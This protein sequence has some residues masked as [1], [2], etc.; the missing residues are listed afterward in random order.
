MEKEELLTV[1]ELARKMGAT[2]RALQYYD[3]EGLLKPSARSEGGRRLYTKKDMI[4]LH[5]ILSMKFLGF[6]LEEIKN[7]LIP[8]ETPQEVTEVLKKQADS[9]QKQIEGLTEALTAIRTLQEEIV[10]MQEV[11]FGK[12]A[13]IISLLRQNN[14]GY[15]VVKYFDDRLLSHIKN[16]FVKQPE[17][18]R[19]LYEDWKRLCDET[20]VLR[21]Q[22]E[23]PSGEKSQRLAGQWWDLI[24][25]FTEGD[26]S[27]LPE[28]IR[29][30]E[31]KR[32]W[33]AE[34]QKKQEIIEDFLRESLGIYLKNKGIEMP[35]ATL[36]E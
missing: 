22:G 23:P 31:S 19:S 5:Q 11:D 33:S 18:G 32:H 28:L 24:M 27:M 16:K 29:F 30:E 17:L 34:L 21:S 25:T 36:K 14:E 6:S 12:Y 13:D 8:L 10:Q 7:N 20:V 35:K 9:I 15:W 1:G 3:R 26:L 4:R 2:V